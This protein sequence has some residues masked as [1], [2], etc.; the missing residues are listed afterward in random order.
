[1]RLPQAPHVL[2]LESQAELL[3]RL[4]LLTNFGSNLISVGGVS[5]A[6]KSWI[7]QRYL[8]VAAQDKNQCL[9][10]CHPNQEDAQHRS[11]IIE[12]LFSEALFNPQEPIGESIERL[13][14][15]EECN[16]VI[17]IDDAHLLSESII[18]ELWM[19]VL[20]A[21]TTQNWSI[22]VLLFAQSG[23]LENLLTRLGYG[24]EQKPVDLEIEPLSEIEA[25]HFFESLV[26]RYVGDDVEKR[27]RSAFKKVHPIPGDI[28][29]LGE[30][31]VEKRIIIRSI[32]GSP[33]NIALIVLLLVL[34]AAGGYWWMFS[35]PSPEDKINS[36]AKM[37]QTA[38]PSLQ[39]S[40]PK[41]SAQP[42][43]PPAATSTPNAAPTS[44]TSHEDTTYADAKDDSQA[45]PPSVVS[46]AG[47]VGDDEQGK[48]RVVIESQVVDALMDKESKLEAA[49]KTSQPQTSTTTELTQS[50]GTPGTAPATA[51]AESAPQATPAAAPAP[52]ANTDKT[53]P[54]AASP[55]QP[56]T[57]IT[58]SFARE[59]L[60]ALSPRAYTL[61]LAA[62]TTLADVQSFLDKYKLQDKVRIYP[63]K[64]G[65]Q[66]WYI[67]TYR[68]YPTIQM[69][70]DAA[71]TLPLAL[72]E[73]NP[74]AKSLSQVQR[75]IQRGK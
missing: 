69:A 55:E 58:F 66:T 70:R 35:Q 34:V 9:L 15:G 42:V 26:V 36:L 73:V 57:N 39:T 24:Q 56:A 31:K 65:E 49:P 51:D 27:V 12:Q 62:M 32:V 23:V 53:Q 7:A 71:E 60:Q 48:Q 17:V 63:T 46:T 75:E 38:L 64:R 43:T 68:D 37:E 30:M 61:Q 47:S 8:E 33:L 59:E 22:N 5:G 44:D 6:G 41:P 19:L 3:E 4:E 45:L 16:I 40:Q 10:L 1:M 20:Q 72:R 67:V 29:A 74:W 14:D 13:L 50:E 54:A 2:E 25:M 21:Q 28:M 11:Q 18:S 52:A